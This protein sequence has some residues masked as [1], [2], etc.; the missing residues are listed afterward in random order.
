MSTFLGFSSAVLS[1]ICDGSYGIALKWT[2][3]W[4][5]EN[6]WLLFSIA[7]LAVF[8]IALALYADRHFW[9]V[10]REVKPVVVWQTLMFGMGWGLGSVCFGLGLYLLG[11]SVA[12]TM[13]MGIIAVGGALIPMLSVAPETTTTAGGGLILLALL[14]TIGG[15]TLCGSAGK[16]RDK[17]AA[18]DQ[19][20]QDRSQFLTAFLICIGG[21]VFSSMFNLAFHFGA[22]ISRAAAERWGEASTSFRANSPIWALAML[23]GFVP[24]A[25]YCCHLL[26]HNGTWGRFRQRDAGYCWLV[27]IAMGAVFAAG[28]T[29]YGIGAAQLGKLGT[30]VAWLMYVATGIL[31]ANVWGTCLGEWRDAPRPAIERMTFGSGVLVLSIALVSWGNYLLP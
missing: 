20:Q 27:G 25:L 11:Q 5:W 13:M 26:T 2:R 18:R 21:G 19:P 1:G 17:L 10:Y 9:E 30:T 22:P 6:I 24:N 12:Y 29:L 23:G 28:I 31:V 8:P 4:E 7:A 16:L 15:V 14:M 3:H